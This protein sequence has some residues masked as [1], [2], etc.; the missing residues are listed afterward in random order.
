MAMRVALAAC[1]ALALAACEVPEGG[2]LRFAP[3]AGAGISAGRDALTGEE[4]AA[5]IRAV[6][7]AGGAV[8]VAGPR[9]YCID[10]ET[11]SARGGG[12]FAMLASCRILAGS[13]PAVAPALITVTVGARERAPVLPD[14]ATLARLVG[15]PAASAETSEGFVSLQIQ[16]GGDTVLAG[17]DGRYWRGAFLQGPRLVSLALY[18]PEGSRLAGA[19]GRALLAEVRRAIAAA[20]PETGTLPGGG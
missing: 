9:G 8:V 15:G 11:V 12:G 17:G 5:P 10:P 2:E 7:M 20:S 1:L 13:G 19:P 18:A 4:E 6:E 3:G 16:E 14:P